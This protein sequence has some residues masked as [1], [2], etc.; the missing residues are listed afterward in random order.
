MPRASHRLSSLA[1]TLVAAGLLA[2][3]ASIN[4][5]PRDPLEPLNRHIFA[6][7]QAVD[8]LVVRPIAVTYRDLVP[9]AIKTAVNNFLNYLKTPIILANDLLQGEWKRAGETAE[10]FVNNSMTLGLM[11]IAAPR[12]PFHDED[13][14][15]TLA[16]WGAG[17]GPYLVLPLIGPSNPR[18]AIGMVVDWFID[19]VY[20]AAHESQW[21]G[22]IF[23]R[24]AAR[25]ITA[26]VDTLKITDD[27]ER[28]SLDYYAAIRDIYR[29]RR[30]D[31]IRNRATG[32]TPRATFG[33]DKAVAAEEP[34][35]AV[36]TD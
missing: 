35:K 5:D 27:L 19:P 32:P 7:N 12:V 14:G 11:D 30:A 6:V 3:C 21:D 36:V 8:V 34:P 10:R 24:T 23:G 22:F 33:E 15:Q 28:T 25:V 29:Q 4:E 26:R 31:E 9:D 1:A 17:E 16:V 20:W 2:G 18:D 13:F